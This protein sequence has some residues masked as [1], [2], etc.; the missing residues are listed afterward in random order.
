MCIEHKKNKIAELKEK[1]KQAEEK[2]ELE[3]EEGRGGESIHKVVCSQEYGES[4]VQREFKKKCERR[5]NLLSLSSSNRLSRPLPIL[6][7][8]C[9]SV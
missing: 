4:N 5:P 6:Y 2:A 3:Q 8:I 7:N 9:K 1:L